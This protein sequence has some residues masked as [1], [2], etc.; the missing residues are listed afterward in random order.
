MSRHRRT[1]RVTPIEE[2]RSSA[3]TIPTDAPEADGTLAWEA[4][5]IVVVHAAGGGERDSA[6]ATPTSR[7]RS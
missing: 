5:T 6:T 1:R 4:T 3:Y 2:S 7:P